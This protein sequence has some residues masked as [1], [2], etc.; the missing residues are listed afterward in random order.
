MIAAAF[1]AAAL[2]FT[3]TDARQAFNYAS[4]LVVKCTPRDAGTLRGTK[5]ANWIFDTVSLLGVNV[6]RDRFT[7]ETPKGARVM[8]NV[9]CTFGAGSG[10]D[11]VV[12]LSHYDTKPGLACPGANDGA[13]T[14]GLLMALA[15]S[16]AKTD[17]PRGNLAFVWTDGEEC[18]ERYA[19]NDG[20]WGSRRAV[21]DFR[22]RGLKIRAVLCLDMLGD[23]DLTVS[24]PANGDESLAALAVDCAR[25]AGLGR[26]FVRRVTDLVTDDHVPFLAAGVPAIDLIDFDY[27][28]SP[29]ANDY[30][31][32]PHDTL[33]K[34]SAD[35]LHKAG[36]LVT[37][38]LTTLL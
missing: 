29:G 12:L 35:S 32:T 20:L 31:H 2:T 28:R 23:R 8:T 24:I 6:R 33:D 30:W 5:A 10:G 22:R 26:R 4:N 9:V 13:S 17:V 34:I 15:A 14:T 18:Q 3:E 7:A 25:R 37:E 19:A 21:D 36:R 27:G 38:M 11:W 1:L 16:L